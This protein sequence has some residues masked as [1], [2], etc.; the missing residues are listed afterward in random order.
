MVVL[1]AGTGAAGAASAQEAVPGTV[2]VGAR[3][4]DPE[5][6]P[7]WA[8]RSWR[9][10]PARG[11]RD[12]PRERCVQAGRLVDGELVRR[13]A[14]GG[15]RV[16][17]LGARTVCGSLAG[18][19]YL[20]LVHEGLVDDPHSS[21]PRPARMIIGGLVPRSVGRVV[22]IVRGAALPLAVDGA[23]AFLA[24][25]PGDVRRAE[26]A[27]RLEGRRRA[28][29]LDFG[30]G[31]G[32]S[33]RLEE[34]SLATELTV[35]DPRGGRPLA[36]VG[37]RLEVDTVRG[38]RTER[39]TEPA[40]IV[41]G[42]VGPY[43]PRWGSFLDAPSLV[44]S[45]GFED[46]WAPL[47]PPAPTIGSCTYA[48]DPFGQG[49]IAAVGVKRFAQRLAILHGILAPGVARL[50]VAGPGAAQPP[51]A[52]APSGAFLVPL[53]S[54]GRLGERVLVTAQLRDGRRHTESVA[55]GPWDRSAPWT[56]WSPLRHGRVLEVR[57]TGGFEPFSSVKVREGRSRIVVRVRERF[58]PAF[59][60]AG[61]P[62]ASA[63]IAI[64][65]CVR[66]RLGAPLGAREVV[67]GA[68]GRRRP[69]GRQP[70]R[71]QKRCHRNHLRRASRSR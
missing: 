6:G 13:F 22:L 18:L 8:L 36:L 65:K 68:T 4:A 26:L 35:P 14:R 29:V 10:R 20:P 34:G 53:P 44:S 11:E 28:R 3:T 9:P 47:A 52:V 51:P 57:W 55:L 61:V 30:R 56:S 23:G 49:P 17:R 19:D 45:V 60:P 7:D 64:A 54:A 32:V 70:P 66:F 71:D 58:P 1:V 33:G 27:L 46:A 67:D 43:E 48:L 24:V 37:Y 40:R 31:G 38:P 16:L 15:Q 41:A 5:G 21:D 63:G 50:E 39:C 2:A 25:L 42:E 69:R 12:A 59:N 62:H